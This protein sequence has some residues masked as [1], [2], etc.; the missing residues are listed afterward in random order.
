MGIIRIRVEKGEEKIDYVGYQ[1]KDCDKAD[2]KFKRSLSS[3]VEFNVIKK[4]QQTRI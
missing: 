2:E 1:G 3:I 4:D